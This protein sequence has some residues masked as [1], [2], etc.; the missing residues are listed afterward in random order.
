MEKQYTEEMKSMYSQDDST[1]R[2]RN[3]DIDLDDPNAG[4]SRGRKQVTEQDAA[5]IIEQLDQINNPIVYA[6]KY[7]ELA[8]Q[9]NVDP[10]EF[11]QMVKE[12]AFIGG[13]RGRKMKVNMAQVYDPLR[14][15]ATNATY[16]DAGRD[17]SDIGATKT[18]MYN[19][20]RDLAP[21]F[22]DNGPVENIDLADDFKATPG[23]F[24]RF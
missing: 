2:G 11:S 18:K 22:E 23:G 13:R 8:D 6:R 5:N 9:E 1:P 17:Q 21:E 7:K 19:L 10:Y 20:N 3:I 12:G 24:K 4:Q 15:T 14:D 16:L